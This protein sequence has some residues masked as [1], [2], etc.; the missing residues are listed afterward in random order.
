MAVV[1][2]AVEQDELRRPKVKQ[3]WCN[4][5][6]RVVDVVLEEGVSAMVPLVT[7]AVGSAIGAGVG[8]GSGAR[9]GAAT[10]SVVGAVIGTLVGLGVQ[11]L[12]PRVERLVCG[13]GCENS[14]G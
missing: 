4:V 11:A 9:R 8:H 2:Y 14:V 13:H 3:L 5:C 1:Q 12:E 10:G 7:T 6:R